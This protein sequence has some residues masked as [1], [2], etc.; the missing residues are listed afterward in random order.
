M[1]SFTRNA[2]RQVRI[3]VL[4]V[5]KLGSEVKLKSTLLLVVLPMLLSSTATITASTI[6]LVLLLLPLLLLL[7]ALPMAG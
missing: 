7:V 2:H 3:H 6:P 5:L 4:P 1:K